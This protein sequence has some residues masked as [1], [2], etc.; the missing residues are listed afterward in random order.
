MTIFEAIKKC[1]RRKNAINNRLCEWALLRASWAI[2]AY[3]EIAQTKE[4]LEEAW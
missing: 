3:K 1:F 2:C 4:I